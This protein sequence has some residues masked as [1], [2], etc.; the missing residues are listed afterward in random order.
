MN[1]YHV[2]GTMRDIDKQNPDIYGS[3]GYFHNPTATTIEDAVNRN[4]VV[5]DGKV[6]DGPLTYVIDTNGS[7]IIGK[8]VDPNDGRKGAPHPTLTGGK[9]PQVQCAGIIIFRKGKILSVDN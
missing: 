3:N 5:V 7:I 1:S 6:P 9:D 8:R 2:V 4:K